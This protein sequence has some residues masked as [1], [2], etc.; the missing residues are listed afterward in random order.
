MTQGLVIR[1][2]TPAGVKAPPEVVRA[3]RSRSAGAAGGD[4]RCAQCGYG[5]TIR[6]QLLRCPMCGAA[7]WEPAPTRAGTRPVEA[8][9]Q[10]SGGRGR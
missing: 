2:E 10:D 9:E 3:R 4:Y 8:S 1:G 6:R 7:A 5:V